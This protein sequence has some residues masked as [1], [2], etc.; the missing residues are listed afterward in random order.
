GRPTPEGAHRDGMELVAVYLLARQ[1][2]KGGES[3]VFEADGPHGQR[4]HAARDEEAG[5]IGPQRCQALAAQR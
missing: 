1:G 4:K 5:E 2:I 3:R